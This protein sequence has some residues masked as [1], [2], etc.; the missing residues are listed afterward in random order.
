MAGVVAMKFDS[1]ELHVL[2]KVYYGGLLQAV[3]QVVF[4]I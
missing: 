4:V 2:M 1:L 3:L